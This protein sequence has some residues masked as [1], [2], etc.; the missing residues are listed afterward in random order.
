MW[1]DERAQSSDVR[2]HSA[3]KLERVVC[4]VVRLG[5]RAVNAGEKSFSHNDTSSLET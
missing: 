2:S 4:V 5:S 1:L 3:V